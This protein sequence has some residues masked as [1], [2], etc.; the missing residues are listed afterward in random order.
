[1]PAGAR[2]SSAELLQELSLPRLR[3]QLRQ[4]LR[5]PVACTHPAATTSAEP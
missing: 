3:R 4:A 2:L 1:V 5:T